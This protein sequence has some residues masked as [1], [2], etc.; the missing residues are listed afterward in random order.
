M[1]SNAETT[2]AMLAEGPIEEYFVFLDLW[3]DTPV[4]LT[5]LP[6]V[7]TLD[8]IDYQ[9][10]SAILAYEPPRLSTIV[11]REIYKISVSD[12]A[13]FYSDQAEISAVGSLMTVRIGF[14]IAGTRRLAAQELQLSYE[15]LVDGITRSTNFQQSEKTVVIEGAS[16][17]ADLD[18]SF[19][20]MTSRDG[21]DQFDTT[22]TSFDQIHEG[23]D[24][25]NLK[26]GKSS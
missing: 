14:K 13:N 4:H 24:A 16:P 26:W 10:D 25:V 2:L 5:S 11:D 23:S 9:P 17:M 7:T 6:V 12:H 15:G 8:T 20:M 19:A 18:S 22:D 21:M 1:K 3:T